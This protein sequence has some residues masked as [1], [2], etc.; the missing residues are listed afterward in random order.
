M[1]LAHVGAEGDDVEAFLAE[2]FEDD[3][4]VEAAGIGED[5]FGLGFAGHG[6]LIDGSD[7]MIMRELLAV[8]D[9]MESTKIRMH[10]HQS[11]HPNAD[12]CGG[13]FSVWCSAIRWAS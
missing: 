7:W 11:N 13:N 3:G 1:V 2:P 10:L 9:W 12:F 6:N 8:I 5:Y 4:G